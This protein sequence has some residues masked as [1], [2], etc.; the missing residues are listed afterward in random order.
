M[1]MLLS[2]A[3]TLDFE[4]PA[5]TELAS[6]PC[7][8][9]QAAELICEL[10]TYS[11]DQISQLMGLSDKLAHLNVARYA[12]WKKSRKLN[13][14]RSAKQC[15]FAFK[16]DV[17]TGLDAERFSKRDIQFAQKHLRILSGLYGLLCPLDVINPYRLEMGTRLKTAQGKD[18]YQFW[19]AQI[20]EQL[21]RDLK[22]M[23]SETV[24]NLASNEYFKS[25]HKKQLNAEVITPVF[26]DEKSGKFKVVSFYAKRARG[27]MA[28]Y[29][30]QSGV[31]EV[32][33]LKS[34]TQAGYW[35]NEEAS[36]EREWVFC[37][38]EGA[39]Q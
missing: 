2:P 1:L 25:V 17:Y 8:L 11:P 5:I 36:S 30:I 7:F 3:K 15:V 16:G 27:M 33:A 38:E 31:K 19:G 21:N 6:E 22:T 26:K 13:V 24:V 10:Q 37:R 14:A 28:A 35:F 29:A 20:T 4:T 39:A 34:F 18:L 9:S 32:Q 23:K 12:S